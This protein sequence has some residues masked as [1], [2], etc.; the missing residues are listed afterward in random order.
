LHIS[1]WLDQVLRAGGDNEITWKA[2]TAT[3]QL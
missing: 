3:S 2:W 1:M